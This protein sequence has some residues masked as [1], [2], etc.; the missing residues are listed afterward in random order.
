MN[1]IKWNGKRIKALRKSLN[2]TQAEFMIQL[3]YEHIQ[4]ISELENNK[5]NPTSKTIILLN[6][7]ESSK[8]K[9]ELK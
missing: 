7:W 1:K 2:M 6:I 9:Y 5:K 3:G 8:K 4:R